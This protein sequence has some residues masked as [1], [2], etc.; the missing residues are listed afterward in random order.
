MDIKY[1]K[2]GSGKKPVS[3]FIN[4]IKDGKTQNIING[5]IRKFVNGTRS[6][7]K[8]I[9]KHQGLFEIIIDYGPGFRI[10]YKTVNSTIY[11]LLA[12]YKGDQT[13]DIDKAINFASEI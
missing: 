8:P 9:T 13:S 3:E 6:H 1:F 11:L 12:G 4:R 5:S 2:T 7:C 10:Y